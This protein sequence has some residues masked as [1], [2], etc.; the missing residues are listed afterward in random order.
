MNECPDHARERDALLRWHV[1]IRVNRRLWLCLSLAIFACCARAEVFPGKGPGASLWIAFR[2]NLDPLLSWDFRDIEASWYLFLVVLPVGWGLLT[3][4]A[5]VY[6]LVSALAGWL[7]AA[8]AASL[9]VLRV[10]PDFHV[11]RR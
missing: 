8:V 11:R 1:P 5:I 7:L 9:R 10:S 6:A 3:L 2:R 4:W